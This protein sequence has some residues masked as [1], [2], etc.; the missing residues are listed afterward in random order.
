MD[1]YWNRCT[2]SVCS[3][4]AE[5]V[6]NNAEKA[7]IKTAWE[8]CDFTRA[9]GHAF[10][11][12]STTDKGTIYIDCTGTPHPSGNQDK[13]LTVKFGKLLTAKP[14]FKSNYTYPNMGIVKRIY[15]Y[16]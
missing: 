10:N 3:D 2:S 14:L 1:I 11:M 4:F 13:I 16:W 12:F 7:G 9:S 8:G 15:T 6:H 5:I